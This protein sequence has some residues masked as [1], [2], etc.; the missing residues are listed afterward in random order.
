MKILYRHPKNKLV[1]WPDWLPPYYNGCNT[2]CDTLEG[3]CACG[4]WHQI[5]E[6]KGDFEIRNFPADASRELR[7]AICGAASVLHEEAAAN[8]REYLKLINLPAPPAIPKT[9][10]FD[11]L[12]SIEPRILEA[13][14]E[15]R[16]FC[17]IAIPKRFDQ[18]AVLCNWLAASGYQ[19]DASELELT[20][21]W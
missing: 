17:R 15:G 8:F 12:Y 11:F 16:R 19:T 14:K 1:A 7:V 9:A 13:A 2:P 10:T 4:A 20:I 6:F 21:L 3:P 5:G 18:M